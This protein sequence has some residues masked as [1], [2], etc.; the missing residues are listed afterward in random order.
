MEH[1]TQKKRGSVIVTK[2]VGHT[3]EDH[4]GYLKVFPNNKMQNRKDGFGCCSLSPMRLGPVNHGQPGLPPC[5]NLENFHQGN[6]C[7]ALEADDNEEP[8][9]LFDEMR[10]AYYEDKEP[11]RHKYKGKKPLYSVW[12]DKQGKIHKV[13]YITSRQFYCIF[14]E[15][16]TEN[17]ED[18]KKLRQMLD[19][20]I[21]LQ[22]VG[23]D[24]RAVGHRSI[25][26]EYLDPAAP[27]GHELVLYTLL[28][29]K[30]EDYPWRKYK[31]FD[32]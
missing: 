23:Y 28:T 15:R 3:P 18:L 24:G 12:V 31:T 4:P 27:F 5:L 2:L 30:P 10:L 21:N 8:A 6:K 14:Y 16:L 29:H 9:P 1:P 17:N 22:I 32:F 20:G 25:E 13:E 19:D 7:F 11:H 26:Q